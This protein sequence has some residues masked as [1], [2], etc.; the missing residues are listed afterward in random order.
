MSS[1]EVVSGP[2]S[3]V[4]TGDK[5]ALRA[6]SDAR[7]ERLKRRD[8][9]AQAELIREE[10]PRVVGV[11]G[12]ILGKGSRADTLVAD[13]FTDFCMHAVDRVRDGRA[14]PAYLRMMAVRRA[15]REKERLERHAEWSE[16]A[17]GV[18]PDACAEVALDAKRR[19]TKLARC[20]EGLQARSRETLRLHYGHD[21]SYS[22][23]GARIGRSK[24]AVGKAVQKDLEALRRCLERQGRSE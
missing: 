2:V 13:L 20:L 22:E 10:T 5:A 16:S 24:Q 1:K 3:L 18:M 17:G 8:S 21:L 14:V 15:R 7:L 23:I 6:A 9:A 19:R 11:V 4:P 12:S